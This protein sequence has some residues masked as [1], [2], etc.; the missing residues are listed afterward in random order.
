MNTQT[1]NLKAKTFMGLLA[2]EGLVPGATSAKDVPEEFFNIVDREIADVK[3]E[4][5]DFFGLMVAA[6]QMAPVGSMMPKRSAKILAFPNMRITRPYNLG[7]EMP[8][9]A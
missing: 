4:G 8:H 6:G 1:Q 3:A 2:A 7:G 5:T 9:A